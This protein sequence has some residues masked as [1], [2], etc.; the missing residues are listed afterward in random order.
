MKLQVVLLALLLGLFSPIIVQGQ[1]TLE[2]SS[3]PIPICGTGE[4]LQRVFS[5]DPER[6]RNYLDAQ[7]IPEHKTV[8]QHIDAQQAFVLPVVF[9]I[10]HDYGAENISDAQ[11]FDALRVLN[12]DFR[13]QNADTSLVDPDFVNL[14]SDSRIQFQLASVDPNGYCTSGIERIPSTRTYMADDLSKLN[15]WPR[16]KYINIWVVQSLA[17]GAAAYAY[18]PGT[19][20][21]A[22]TDG[23]LVRASHVGSI[24]ASNPYNA[25]TLTHEMGHFL[26]LWHTWGLSNG[27]GILC[28]DDNVADTPDTQGWTYC[29]LANNDVCTG[30]VKENVQNFMEYSYCFLMFTE[31][32]CE[33]MRQALFSSVGERDQLLINAPSLL[34][35]QFLLCAP[36]ADFMPKNNVLICAGQYVNFQDA[37]WNGIPSQW[38]WNFAGGMPA[39]STNASQFVQYLNPGVHAVSLMSANASG[40]STITRA[41]AVVVL[42]A[43]S[44]YHSGYTENF[45]DTTRFHTECYSD[46]LSASENE[47]VITNTAAS[48]GTYSVM[49]ANGVWMLNEYAEM[50]LPPVDLASMNAPVFSF[51]MAFGRDAFPCI[52]SLFVYASI[53]CGQTWIKR[54]SRF[55]DNLATAIPFQAGFVPTASEWRL[56]NVSLNAN[57]SSS[58][59]V[60]FK[61]KFVGK[62]GSNLY[63]DDINIVSP[64]GISSSNASEF[65]TI[66]P[67]PAAEQLVLH[68]GLV[69]K[70]SMTIEL[71]DL[72]GRQIALLMQGEMEAG[73]HTV[74]L[75]AGQ[76]PRSGI[77]FVRLIASDGT[78]MTQKVVIE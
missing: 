36:V 65:F 66:A 27:P 71:L 55:G 30:G 1:A 61:F 69:Q 60:L 44:N 34:T 75:L 62:G 31:G 15:Y 40:S 46:S 26:N 70:Q 41:M 10:I 50:I 57:I 11:V 58:S 47:F 16:N 68:I 19:A 28:G 6:E 14:V 17:N 29:E 38:A 3:R 49:V 76:M 52:D 35:D 77:Y 51:K 45:E 21:L 67:N 2:N 13:K 5:S 24:G 74:N 43:Q 42:P 72:A 54:Y 39:S 25:R 22:S 12:E 56:E 53:D 8:D 4:N 9:H 23:I 20:S 78:V 32:Q 7:H 18:L 59:H 63:I 33:R 64:S 37:S 73:N 48:S